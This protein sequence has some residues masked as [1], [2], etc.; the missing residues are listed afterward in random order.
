M[1]VYTRIFFVFE[2]VV[3]GISRKLFTAVENASFGKCFYYVFN[4]N[5]LRVL[6]V[7]KPYDFGFFFVY[8][9]FM[10]FYFIAVNDSSA[11][12]VAFL[13]C[14]VHSALYLLRK[15]GRIIFGVALNHTFEY[16][17][18]GAVGNIFGS[19]NDF[20]AV[21]FKC[22]LVFRGFVFITRKPI[23]FVNEYDIEIVFFAIFYH[24]TEVGAI[25]VSTRHSTVYIGS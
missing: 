25:V 16:N 23:E 24:L 13:S 3:D 17:R 10:I 1:S 19:G 21:V 22:F 11:R 4:V 7:N 18:L 8:Y 9:D 12:K 14:F 20:N 5:A 2:Y 15:F 6:V